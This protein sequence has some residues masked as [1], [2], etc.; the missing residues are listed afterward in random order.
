M[1]CD[2]ERFIIDRLVS[3]CTLKTNI[4]NVSTN[5]IFHGCNCPWVSS[6]WQMT[7]NVSCWAVCSLKYTTCYTAVDTIIIQKE[8]I[9][10]SKNLCGCNRVKS[11]HRIR[12]SNRLVIQSCKAI[13]NLGY[14]KLFGD[15]LSTICAGN[16]HV[17][18]ITRYD[19]LHGCNCKWI[20]RHWSSNSSKDRWAI[21]LEQS[22]GVYLAVS[23]I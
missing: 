6:N 1:F 22:A 12:R 18:Y 15:C 5:Y 9:P 16:T 11:K 4:L 7:R 8:R 13:P 3:I 17:I 2:F 21:G 20:S 19:V 14:L 23:W 10:I